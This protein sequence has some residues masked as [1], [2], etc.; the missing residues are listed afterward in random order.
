MKQ[1]GT[2][3]EEEDVVIFP[4]I[5]EDVVK[6]QEAPKRKSIKILLN[7]VATYISAVEQ[8]EESSLN[9]ELPSNFSTDT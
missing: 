1:L 5:L 4:E 8:S 7:Y 9:Q 6:F 2:I 3:N